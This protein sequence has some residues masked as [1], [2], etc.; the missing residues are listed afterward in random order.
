VL[1]R[2]NALHVIGTPAAGV[3]AALAIGDEVVRQVE[4]ILA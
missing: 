1:R 2:E 3:A 4:E